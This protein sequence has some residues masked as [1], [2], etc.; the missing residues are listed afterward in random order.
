MNTVIAIAAIAG[1]GLLLYSIVS[2]PTKKEEPKLLDKISAAFAATETDYRA[3]IPGSIITIARNTPE[4]EAKYQELKAANVSLLHDVNP[5]LGNTA[6]ID[7]FAPFTQGWVNAQAA[8][9]T[10]DAKKSEPKDKQTSTT[11]PF[12]IFAFKGF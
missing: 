8:F 10:T 11:H 7:F 6:K 1:A 3:R 5:A 9:R 2:A 12:D 4:N